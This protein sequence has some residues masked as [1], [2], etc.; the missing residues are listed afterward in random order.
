MKKAKKGKKSTKK[1]EP[2]EHQNMYEI[3]PFVD[4]K[5]ATPMVKLNIRLAAPVVEPLKF[6]LEVPITTRIEYIKRKIIEQ[7]HGAISNLK[8]CLETFSPENCVD[9]DKTLEELNHRSEGDINVYY[10]FEPISYPLLIT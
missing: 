4:P 3:P 5:V 9:H 10:D 6:Q 2:V 7:H 1:K 8:I